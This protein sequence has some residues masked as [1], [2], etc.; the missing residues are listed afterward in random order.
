MKQLI[1][2]PAVAFVVSTAATTGILVKLH[3]PVPVAPAVSPRAGADSTRAD[4]SRRAP[5]G[6]DSGGADSARMDSAVK[7]VAIAKHDSAI[8]VARMDSAPQG[9]G[10]AAA[11]LPRIPRVA[12]QADPAARA[13]AY[14]QVA[15][16][17]SAMKPPEAAKVIA[18][19]TDQEVEGILRSVGPRQA[20]DFL[21]NLPKERAATLSRRLLVPSPKDETR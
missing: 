10:V 17:L 12:A 1:V 13:A 20:A 8:A 6:S 4:S 5:S 3:K 19:L 18:Y 15:R 21:T 7:P 16:V 9:A 14:K 11:A 2:F